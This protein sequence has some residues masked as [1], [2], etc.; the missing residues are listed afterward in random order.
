MGKIQLI[1]LITVAFG[2]AGC[3]I[4]G[5]IEDIQV[6]PVSVL[7]KNS[8]NEF[9]SGAVVGSVTSGNYVVN[10]ALGNMS[11]QLV[12]ETPEQGYQ[13]FMTVQGRVYSEAVEQPSY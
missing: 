13:V 7:Q 11:P 9:N 4:K 12:S 2:L 1:T 5:G 8:S 3:S 10:H 6:E